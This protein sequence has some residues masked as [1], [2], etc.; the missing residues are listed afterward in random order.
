MGSG[1]ELGIRGIESTLRCCF[2]PLRRALKRW[3]SSKDSLNFAQGR[4]C[5][6]LDLRDNSPSATDHPFLFR[7]AYIFWSAGLPYC[8]DPMNSEERIRALSMKVAAAPDDSEE[9]SVAM[10]ELREAL[11]E[12]ATS[13]RNKI[14][15]LKQKAFPDSAPD[16]S[17]SE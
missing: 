2:V 3:T 7:L 14:A 10:K 12:N 11:N 8:S 15:A 4:L 17:G 5:P 9:F 1:K 6:G 16:N 13:A